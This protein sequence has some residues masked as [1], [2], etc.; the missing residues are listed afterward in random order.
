[1]KP[2]RLTRLLLAGTLG[3][4]AAGCKD[5]PG[6]PKPGEGSDELRPE[7]VHDFAKLYKENCAACHG[8]NGQHAASISLANPV[9]LAYAG[10]ANIQ[11]AIAAGIPGT[12]MPG[13]S[14]AAGGMLTD[15]QIAII[16]HG[17]VT[18]WGKP[19]DLNGQAIPS[20][21]STVKGDPSAG[22]KA[23]TTF[24]ASCH[25][26]D[27]TGAAPHPGSIVDPAYLALVDDQFL[28]SNIVA[29]RPEGMPD[30]RSH[31]VS[32]SLHVINSDEIDDIVAWLGSHRIATPG[33]PYQQ[34]Q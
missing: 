21:A 19:L 20:Y 5:V 18:G 33:Q 11:K 25:G 13:F 10:E 14:K 8:E 32:G 34:H 26:A 12:L 6:K 7:Q 24:C 15:E 31:I 17:M 27:G 22:Q 3:L 28:R 30:W 2:R 1:M 4:L 16:A 23:F 9:Y 29:G